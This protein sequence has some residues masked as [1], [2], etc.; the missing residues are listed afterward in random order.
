MITVRTVWRECGCSGTAVIS[1]GRLLSLRGE[2]CPECLA[3]ASA[4][5]RNPRNAQLDIFQ[6]EEILTDGEKK[7]G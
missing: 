4:G 2:T 5:D 1:D 7:G 6:P 3:A